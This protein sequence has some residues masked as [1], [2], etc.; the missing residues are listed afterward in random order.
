LELNLI[1][2]PCCG[3]E[4]KNIKIL[5][6]SNYEFDDHNEEKGKSGGIPMR[7]IIEL[8]CL[9]CG[10][11]S[12]FEALRLMS[13][14]YEEEKE[15]SKYCP[16]GNE[17][18]PLDERQ[19]KYVEEFLKSEDKNK[20]ARNADYSVIDAPLRQKKINK[21]INDGRQAKLEEKKQK[22]FNKVD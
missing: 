20:A 17:N 18:D 16:S 9:E 11:I 14:Y 3:K 4:L 1:G 5:K 15:F 21:A 8:I 13:K 6:M 12:R 19:K 10:Y 22:K 7:D 2:C